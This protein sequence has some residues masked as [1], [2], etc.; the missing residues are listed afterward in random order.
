MAIMN[1]DVIVGHVPRELSQ[2][3]FFFI[4]IIE[5]DGEI[6]YKITGRWQRSTLLVGGLKVPCT[7]TLRGQK[8]LVDKILKSMS[9]KIVS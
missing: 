4:I 8:K 6:N 9:I 7:Y 3:F 1:G 2:T 5:R